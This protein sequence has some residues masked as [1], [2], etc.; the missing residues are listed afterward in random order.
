MQAGH[1]DDL[2]FLCDTELVSS[3]SGRTFTSFELGTNEQLRDKDFYFKQFVKFEDVFW[4]IFMVTI[5]D[6][7]V[8]KWF[9][10]I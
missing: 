10:L 1:H 6:F 2:L 9:L 4:N 8:K 5:G 3:W 7:T